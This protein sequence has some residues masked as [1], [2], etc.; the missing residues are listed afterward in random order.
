MVTSTGAPDLGNILDADFVNPLKAFFG[1][2]AKVLT[3][4]LAASLQQ[5]QTELE[6]A[7]NAASSAATAAQASID[8]TIN[9]VVDNGLKAFAGT[10]ETT[11]PT[12]APLIAAG[13]PIAET[14]ANGVLDAI[15]L[16]GITV[17]AGLLSGAAKA[18]AAANLTTLAGAS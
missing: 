10:L 17:F 6:N 12:L 13:E 11:A 16:R 4:D 9:P 7:L 8:T 3:G 14:E 18:V 15:A 2:A 5:G 1:D